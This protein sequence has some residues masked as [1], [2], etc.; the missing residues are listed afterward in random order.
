M[1][2][3]FIALMGVSLL[4]GLLCSDR[5][6]GTKSFNA[7]YW[8]I[9]MFGAVAGLSLVTAWILILLEGAK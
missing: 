1:I 7:R 8:L 4:I 3:F 6:W 5:Y 2:E 9:M